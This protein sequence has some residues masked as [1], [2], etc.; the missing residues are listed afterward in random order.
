MFSGIDILYEIEAL[1]TDRTLGQIKLDTKAMTVR[2]TPGKSL[3]DS[4][5]VGDTI[6]KQFELKTCEQNSDSA[7]PT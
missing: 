3:T 6:K 7:R 5:L 2:F 4:R 1:I